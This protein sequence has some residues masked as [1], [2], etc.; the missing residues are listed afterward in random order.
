MLYTLGLGSNIHPRRNTI[1]KA[2]ILIEKRIGEV[3]DASALYESEPWGFS[4]NTWFI[5]Q[6]IRVNSALA[7][8]EVLEVAQGIE[9]ELGRERHGTGYES[10]T[11]DIDILLAERL[12]IEEPQLRI[13]HPHMLDRRF[14][15]LPMLDIAPMERHPIGHRSWTTLL[16]ECADGSEVKRV[17]SPIPLQLEK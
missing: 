3:R 7:P 15:L 2:R 14:V 10:R 5:N 1:E 12:L 6:N 17:G 13:P 16:A 4:A 9:N 11:I 8:L